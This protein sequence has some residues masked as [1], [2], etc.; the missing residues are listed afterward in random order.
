MERWHAS[1]EDCHHDN[2]ECMYAGLVP[3]EERRPGDGGKPLC[4]LCVRLDRAE[5]HFSQRS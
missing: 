1:G 2:T 4:G 5:D 3:A